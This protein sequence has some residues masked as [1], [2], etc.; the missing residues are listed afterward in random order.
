M[1]VKE[2]VKWPG[3]YSSQTPFPKEKS[4]LP[5]SQS[6]GQVEKMTSILALSQSPRLLKGKEIVTV[7]TFFVHSDPSAAS[8]RFFG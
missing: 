1:D 2:R 7:G 6:H 3:G 8:N 5:L 4:H